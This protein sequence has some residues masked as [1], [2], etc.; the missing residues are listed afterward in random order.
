[1]IKSSQKIYK[2][3]SIIKSL[4]K[5]NKSGSKTLCVVDKNN[6]LLGTFSDGDLR[7]IILKGTD[8]DNII[9]GHYNKNPTFFYE[10]IYVIYV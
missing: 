8:L 10:N 3:E 4:Q 2:T 1:M 6:T 9:D 7:K 5:M